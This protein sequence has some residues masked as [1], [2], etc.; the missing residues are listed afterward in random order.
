MSK[1]MCTFIVIYNS[2]LLYLLVH[3]H[4][5]IIVHPC[6]WLH[7]SSLSTLYCYMI[8]C[9]YNSTFRCAPIQ[10]H[11]FPGAIRVYQSVIPN[12]NV[13]VNIP[14]ALLSL[15]ISIYSTSV[16]SAI[17][18]HSCVLMLVI[19][20]TVYYKYFSVFCCSHM[21]MYRQWQDI[22]MQCS[23]SAPTPACFKHSKTPMCS[24]VCIIRCAM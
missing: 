5:T 20:S 4:F 16:C 23:T 10:K 12:F 9:H 15:S 11:S 7:S 6:P 2:V 18:L 3:V 14:C 21:P 19:L 1:S 8:A 17:V 13:K 22:S 24:D